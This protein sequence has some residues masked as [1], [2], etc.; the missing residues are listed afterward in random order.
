MP[1]WTTP[2][3]LA[4]QVLRVWNK[5]QILAAKLAGSQFFPLELRLRRPGT[6]DFGKRFDEVRR[7]IRILEEGARGRR[8]F[9]Y[10]IEWIDIN[11]QQL[12]RNRV[13]ARVWV[14]SESDAV[15]LIGKQR[16]VRQFDEVVQSTSA[17][18]PRLSEWLARRSLVALEHAQDWPRILAVLA[19]F[20]DH[21]RSSLYLRQIDIPGIDTKFVESRKP[22]LSELLDVVLAGPTEL[23]P[24]SVARAFEE[25]YGLRAKPAIVRFRALDKSLAIGGLL[26]IGTPATEFASLSTMARRIFITENE[27]NGLAFPDVAGGIVI[28]GLGYSLDILSSAIWMKN[29]EIYYWGDIDTHGFAMLDRLRAAFP[30]ARSLLMD[31]ETLLAHRELWVCEETPY[32]GALT[33]LESDERALFEDLVHDRLGKGVRLEQERISFGRLEQTLQGLCANAHRHK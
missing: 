24:E 12:G 20:R 15:R 9:G 8:G 22:L 29:R 33:R 25:R 6:K 26:D 28:F 32:R 1:D 2:A 19:W 21:P 4:E 30:S 3:D 10:D 17:A 14:L 5:G 23:E 7:W 13:P 31:R 27:V 18:L 11:H 16:E